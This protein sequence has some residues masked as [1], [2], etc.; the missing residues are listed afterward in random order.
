M[1]VRLSAEARRG[2]RL[3]PRM[4]PRGR[5]GS[6]GRSGLTRREVWIPQSDAVSG[7]WAR[8][9]SNQRPLACE[10]S[11]LPLSYAPGAEQFTPMRIGVAVQAFRA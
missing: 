7:L 11:A 4:T 1:A 9:V 3:T 10:A 2:A 8:L 6:V 5:F